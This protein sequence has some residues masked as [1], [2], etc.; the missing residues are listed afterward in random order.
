LFFIIFVFRKTNILE[1]SR[2]I[3]NIMGNDYRPIAAFQHRAGALAIRFFDT[4]DRI[5]A[6]TV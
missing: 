6:K 2:V 3:S 1:A 5:D 4:Y